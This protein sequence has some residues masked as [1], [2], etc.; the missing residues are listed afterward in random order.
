MYRDF[1]EFVGPGTAHLN[2]LVLKL[3]GARVAALG[4]AA[5]ALG[6][7][8]GVLV[9]ALAS[10]FL[11]PGWRLLPSAAFLS[12][13]YAPYTFGDHKWPA[14][15][16]CFAAV[17]LALRA[18]GTAGQVGAGALLGLAVLFTQDL[19]LGCAAGLTAF[20]YRRQGLRAAAAMVA[21]LLLPPLMV[22][23]F[24]A[25][26]AGLATIAYDWVVFPFTRYRELN[27]FRLAAS[28]SARTLPRDAAQ[29][30]LAATGVLG[31]L[32]ALRARADETPPGVR[33]LSLAGLG[34]CAATAHRGFYPAGLAVQ[35]ALLAPVAVWTLWRRLSA[36][37]WRARPLA[38]ASAAVLL[39]GILY[40]SVGVAAWRQFLQPLT[41]E[42]H[43][44][45]AV[46]TPWPM[47]ELSWIESHT[48]EGEAAFLLPARGG[49]YLLTR[50][51]D[52]T[53]FPY[54]IEGQHTEEQ[55]R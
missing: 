18:Q 46:W 40:G 52:V 35:S 15:L 53:G 6:A 47:P 12:L 24:F 43:R 37:P 32:W 10:A 33:A 2:A 9:H 19:G 50:T 17:A 45:G 36:A 34:A 27:R 44:A 41:R 21:G 8:L 23:G 55:A 29:L 38:A 30:A 11:P 4:V 14:L 28:V 39:A 16:L 7:A 25:W 13:A 5:V 22:M 49:H 1:F 51:R 54:I 48:R 26:K 20:A 42:R 31:A 3:A